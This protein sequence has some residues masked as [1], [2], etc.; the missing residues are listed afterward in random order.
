M[1]DGEKPVNRQ[2]SPPSFIPPVYVKEGSFYLSGYKGVAIWFAPMPMFEHGGYASTFKQLELTRT[3]FSS[4][5]KLSALSMAITF[6]FGLLFWSLIWKLAPIPSAAYPYIDKMWPLQATMQV[7]WVR[8]TL[9]GEGGKVLE[10]IIQ[11][12]Y[13]GVGFLTASLTYGLTCLVKAPTLLFYGFIGGIGT[14]PHFALPTFVGALLGR[15]YF[16]RRFG[17]ERWAAYTPVVLAGYGCGLGL[18]GMTSVA[19][20][21]IA[22]ATEQIVF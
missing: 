7:I 9:P 22:K 2:S 20:A 8:S 18:V 1:G 4:L 6:V 11:W 10:Q 13:I 16:A 3:R 21:L 12:K 14:W 17:A 5:V 19:L 15:Y